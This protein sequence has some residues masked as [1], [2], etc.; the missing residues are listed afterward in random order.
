VTVWVVSAED[1]C[2]SDKR[3]RVV[4][5]FASSAT[6]RAFVD[7]CDA[8]ARAHYDQWGRPLLTGPIPLS[9]D[10]DAEGDSCYDVNEAAVFA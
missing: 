9:P 3:F 7:A 4:R 10:P 8:W 5:V 1:G 6:A 2:F